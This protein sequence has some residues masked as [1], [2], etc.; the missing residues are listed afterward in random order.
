MELL[1]AAEYFDSIAFTQSETP[2]FLSARAHYMKG[3]GYYERDSV[4]EACREYLQALEIME[5]RFEEKDLVGK[6]ARFMAL[7]FNRLFDLF[8]SQYMMEPAISCAQQALVFFRVAPL[9][10]YSVPNTLYQIGVQYDALDEIDSADYYYALALAQ[11][12]DTTN[13]YYRD[14]RSSVALFDYLHNQQGAAALQILKQMTDGADD[15][16]ERLTRYFTIGSLFFMEGMYDSALV[17]L[18]P[19]FNHKSNKEIKLQAAD[20]LAKI[21]DIHGEHDKAEAYI[22]F[23]AEHK[24]MVADNKAETSKL[25][26][27]FQDYINR[28][29]QRQAEAE[30]KATHKRTVMRSLVIFIPIVLMLI[31][32]LAWAL[33][34]RQRK[35]LMATE[36]AARQ[37][38]EAT[39]LQYK[40][41]LQQHQAEVGK[42]LDEAEERLRQQKAQTEALKL[43]MEKQEEAEIEKNT[44][45]DDAFLCETVCKKIRDSVLLRSIT[46]RDLPIEH[47]EVV[48]DE[49]TSVLFCNIVNQRFEGLEAQLRKRYPRIKAQDVLLCY[50]HLLDLDEKQMA[51]LLNLTYSA[52]KKKIVRLQVYLEID[53]NLANFMKKQAGLR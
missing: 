35:H 20:Y 11:M 53:E 4:T 27:L 3:V 30:Q 7:T 17:Y 45:K 28:K 37:Q 33:K 47:K 25:S 40:Q 32:V 50:L 29:Q 31:P 24:V 48:L 1:R 22:R 34:K 10:A 8:S 36:T 19:V 14:L 12:P 21:H 15:E 41:Q 5:G 43:E 39:R 38:L 9:S 49:D 13:L 42:K 2:V 52:V 26:T 44:N 16:E 18:Q 23:L 51:A 6:K 46:T